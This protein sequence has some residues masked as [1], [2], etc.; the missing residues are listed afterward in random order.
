MS[1]TL[2]PTYTCAQNPVILWE[3]L[4]AESDSAIITA[5]TEVGTNY[6][7]N[8]FDYRYDTGW[9]METGTDEWVDIDFG[10]NVTVDAVGMWAPQVAQV[11]GTV[12]LEASLDEV[13]YVVLAELD[14]VNSEAI[15][16]TF[17]TISRRFWRVRFSAVDGGAIINQL[18]F[19]KRLDLERGVR[20]DFGPLFLSRN[21]IVSANRT[22]DGIP[23]IRRKFAD[24]QASN[25]TVNPISEEWARTEWIC[26][27][28]HAE[29]KPWFFQW[30]PTDYPEEVGLCDVDSSIQPVKFQT[31]VWMQTSISFRALGASKEDLTPFPLPPPPPPPQV[32]CFPDEGAIGDGTYYVLSEYCFGPTWSRVTVNEIWPIDYV[33]VT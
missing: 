7:Q 32:E 4:P 8:L 15:L 30:N 23:M 22:R 25:M 33:E 14:P 18:Y 17:D 28:Q 12:F 26:F 5:T 10:E 2:V 6:A 24:I 29:V 1:S 16:K 19:G 13:S 21:N 31:N 27:I 9:L 3:N 20:I 11:Q